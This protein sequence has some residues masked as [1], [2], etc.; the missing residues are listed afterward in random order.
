MH[1]DGHAAEGHTMAT[2]AYLLP[3]P[4]WD[5]SLL[6]YQMAAIVEL[7]NQLRQISFHYTDRHMIL[8]AGKGH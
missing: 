1:S 8:F 7:V 2:L 4:A 5:S 6:C 3:F